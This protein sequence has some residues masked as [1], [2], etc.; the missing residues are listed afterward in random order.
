MI[1][2]VLLDMGGVLIGLQNARGL[3]DSRYDW[4]GRQALLSLLRRRGRKVSEKD[5]DKLLFEPWRAE[6]DQR[7]ERGHEADWKPHLTRL[8]KHV[9][10]RLH[11]VTLLAAWFRPYGEELIALDGA[12]ETLYQLRRSGLRLGLVSNVP[13]PGVLYRKILERHGMAVA[14][15]TFHFSYDDGSRK[16]SPAMIR[17]ALTTLGVA[18][19]AALMVGDRRTSDVAAGRAAG[20]DTVWIRTDDGGGPA[21]D[22]TIDKISQLPALVAKLRS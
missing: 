20:V 1:E 11:D 21:P 5:L 15:D 22:H 12:A 9:G 13:M 17:H 16:P 10:S 2:A 18:P 19:S 14:I 7:Y 4:R 3:P 6:Y 8:R